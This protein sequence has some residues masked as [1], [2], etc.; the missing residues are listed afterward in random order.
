MMESFRLPICRYSTTGLCLEGN[1]EQLRH[2]AT[3]L[4]RLG[5][6]TPLGDPGPMPATPYDGFVRTL[7]VRTG[8]LLRLALQSDALVVSGSDASRAWLAEEIVR[9][10]RRDVDGGATHMHFEAWHEH[11]FLDQRSEPLVVELIES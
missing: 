6:P 2:F 1:T 11:P 7:E 5:G 4:G 9:F 8:E 3:R 10:A